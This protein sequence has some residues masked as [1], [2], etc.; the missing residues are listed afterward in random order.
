MLEDANKLFDGTHL[1]HAFVPE[2]VLSLAIALLFARLVCRPR[3]SRRPSLRKLW[4]RIRRCVRGRGAE[5]TRATIP[6]RTAGTSTETAR[7]ANA[8]RAFAFLALSCQA[9]TCDPC[10]QTEW[11]PS[12]GEQAS[13]TSAAGASTTTCGLCGRQVCSPRAAELHSRPALAPCYSAI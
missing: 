10:S 2:L 1:H 8:V 6:P 7:V 11:S 5:Q 3:R 9:A 12:G 4:C 13:T